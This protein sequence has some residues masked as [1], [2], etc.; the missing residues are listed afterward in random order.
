M[1]R[2]FTGFT[3]A[4]S[5]CLWLNSSM[6]AQ[7]YNKDGNKLQLYGKVDTLHMFS[8]NT[9]IDGDQTYMRF[10]F[11]GETQVNDLITGYGQ[12]EQQIN[13]NQAESSTNTS[14][15]RLGYAG[16]RLGQYGSV[17]YGRNFGVLYDIGSWTDVIPEFGGDAYGIDNFMFKRTTGL[18]TYRNKNFF[19]LN[20]KLHLA[21]Q[22]Q[23]KNGGTGETNNSR[24]VLQQ[25]GDGY[26][27]SL[28]YDLGA[29]VSAGATF[30]SSDRTN[31]QNSIDYGRGS[32]AE[33]YR[34]G[35]KYD[36]N[37][38]YLAATYTQTYNATPFG[39]SSHAVYG[40]ANQAH[41]MELIAQYQFLSGL[42]PIVGYLQ[43][44]GKDIEG[45]GDQTI[46]KYIAFGGAYFF[47]KNMSAD[48]IYKVNLLDKNSFTQNSG[49]NVDDV[50]AVAL[51]Y[52]F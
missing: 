1:K 37:Q 4:I 51:I 48:V 9:S 28:I 15:T 10:G 6:A 24:G 52:Y 7:I 34:A 45:Y 8:D 14:V 33:A 38:I 5:L 19:G 3:L 29:G 21:L 17:D 31:G 32:K 26:G 25:N 12:W 13:A 30:S 20:E 50:L 16:L 23:G 46:L 11:K 42:A 43:T 41:V 36:A 39:S 22:Y 47:N 27:M 40:F 18:L 44:D 35:V 2:Q 49:I